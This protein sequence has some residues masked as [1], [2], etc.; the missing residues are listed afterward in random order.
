MQLVYMVMII[1]IIWDLAA[2]Y[3]PICNVQ[4]SNRSYILSSSIK[5]NHVITLTNTI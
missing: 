3:G 1:K 5:F 2:Y 4:N